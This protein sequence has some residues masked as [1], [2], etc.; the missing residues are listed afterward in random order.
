MATN[1][2]RRDFLA[3]ILPRE[4]IRIVG[5]AAGVCEDLDPSIQDASETDGAPAEEQD[6]AGTDYFSSFESCYPLLSECG[7]ML[8]EE[9]S[10]LHIPIEGKSRLEMARAIWAQ[11]TGPPPSQ[12][13]SS[14]RE[15]VQ[16]SGQAKQ[17]LDVNS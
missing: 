16:Q 7:S 14:R 11:M 4:A 10:R 15:P 1:P 17:A 5:E 2:G 13:P 6:G 12:S 9:A 3:R 8:A